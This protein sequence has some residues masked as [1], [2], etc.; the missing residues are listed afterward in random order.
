M[1]VAGREPVWGNSGDGMLISG[2]TP[3]SLRNCIT[4]GVDE[5]IDLESRKEF[6]SINSL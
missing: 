6:Q 3:T 4:T 5:T 2:T 1:K